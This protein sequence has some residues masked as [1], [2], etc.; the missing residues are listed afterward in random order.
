[1]YFSLDL[2]RSRGVIDP[3]Q[4]VAMLHFPFRVTA[5]QLTLELELDDRR[6]LLHLSHQKIITQASA[7]GFESLGWIVGVN[8]ARQLLERR[9]D[10][11]VAFLELR[12][13]P[14]TKRDAHRR[15]NQRLVA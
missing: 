1:M 4:Q 11:S 10:Q 8:S 13:A 15:G 2:Y 5:A 12:K 7:A 9:H 3:V 6:G 14:V